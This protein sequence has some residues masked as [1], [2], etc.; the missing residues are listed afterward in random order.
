VSGYLKKKL[1]RGVII[2]LKLIPFKFRYLLLENLAPFMNLA[3]T[4]EKRI[5]KEQLDYFYRP[6][7]KSP[8]SKEGSPLMVFKNICRTFAEVVDLGTLLKR[9]DTQFVFDNLELFENIRLRK[10]GILVL[11]GH[12]SNWELLGAY[13]ANLGFKLNVIA[14]KSRRTA[15]QDSLEEIR[16][17]SGVN[18]LWRSDEDNTLES[19]RKLIYSLTNGEIVALLID[20]DTRVESIFCDFFGKPAKTPATLIKIALKRDIPIV[21][22]FLIREGV[23]RYRIKLFEAADRSSIADVIKF[24]NSKLEDVICYE[25]NQWVWFHKRWKSRPSGKIYSTK[26]YVKAL[27]NNALS[28]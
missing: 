10:G 14:K 20:Q 22:T 1:L 18:T 15:L 7:L 12:Y 2:I 4:R 25:P 17:S 11:T 16:R 5:I 28:D 24:Y 3:L 23:G 27:K 19:N 13:F 26:E 8:S 9:R 21:V 6:F